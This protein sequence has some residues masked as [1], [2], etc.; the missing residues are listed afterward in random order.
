MA[1][2]TVHRVSR[3]RCHLFFPSSRTE[4]TLVC[5]LLKLKKN[6]ITQHCST[7]QNKVKI[8]DVK[9]RQKKKKNIK[10]YQF[11]NYPMEVF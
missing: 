4:C 3:E 8:A 5:V 2:Q 10:S 7:W 11:Q 9:S 1:I 6:K